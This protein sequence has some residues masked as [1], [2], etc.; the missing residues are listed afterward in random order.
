VNHQQAPRVPAKL[1]LFGVYEA[2]LTAGELRKNGRPVRLQ[3]Q[4]FQVLAALLDRAGEVVTRE[5]LRERLWPSDSFGDFDQALNV[6]INKLR[7]ALGDSAANPRFIE[8]LPKRGY[9]FT[10]PLEAAVAREP[11]GQVQRQPWLQPKLLVPIAAVA[12]I[13]TTAFAVLWVRRPFPE[14][15]LPLRRFAIRRPVPL[16]TQRIVSL[17]SVSPNGKHVAIIGD[18]AERKLWIQD[19]DQRHPRVI[20]GSEAAVSPFWSPDSNMIGFAAAGKLKKVS[21]KG[22]PVLPLC[23]MADSVVYGGSWSPD[24]GSI[25]FAA[26][27]PSALYVVPA[28]GGTA[29]L[30]VSAQML[31]PQPKG[32]GWVVQPYFLPAGARDSV[33]LFVYHRTLMA[34]DLKTGQHHII[35][36]AGDFSYSST[37][38]LLYRSGTDLWARLFSSKQLRFEGEAFLVARNATDPSVASDGTLVYRD[39]VVEQLA[40]L[41]RRGTRI[42]TVGQ[43][44]GLFTY[45][46]LSPD[47]RRVA[48]ETLENDNLDVWVN[49]IARG[50]RIRLSSDPAAEITPAW[51]PGGDRV[52]FSSYRAGSTDIYVRSAD[53]GS[54]EKPLP[55]TRFNERVSDWSRDGQY[56][57]YS[58]LHPKNGFD[59]W[60]LKRIAEDNWEPHPLLETAF[61]E[62]IPKLSPDGRYVAYLSDES[63]RD[64]VYV[65]QF[66]AGGHKWPVS[67]HGASQIRWSRNGQELFYAETG[68]LIA[69]PVKTISVFAAGPATRLFSHIAL[70]SAGTEPNYD[71]SADGQRILLPDVVGPERMTHVVQN[72]FAEFRDR[73]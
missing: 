63:G 66:P 11:G 6:A 7:E 29:K 31:E 33:V 48:V 32:G 42:G 15:Q 4:P 12:M 62:K 40:W 26:G 35:G 49:D 36:P 30:L 27:S 25:V 61:N 24:G 3:E 53:A 44:A 43:P 47:D 14:P 59:L 10:H 16:R 67:S 51:A 60:C 45:P 65:R 55:A 2:D 56:I 69:V 5:E 70:T 37:G 46:T 17:V 71:V 20:E 22:G 72:W 64:E 41:D 50:T 54:E 34:W 38:H 19:L 52:A 23:D 13:A 1:I 39:A 57:L 58:L 73:R 28:T 21:V 68:A 9:R 18:E 8:T